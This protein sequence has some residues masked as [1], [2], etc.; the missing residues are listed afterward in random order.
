M[1][2]WVYLKTAE[3]LAVFWL[4]FA[5]L[6]A[7][8][9]RWRQKVLA[10]FV[11]VVYVLI[12][13]AFAGLLMFLDIKVRSEGINDWGFLPLLIV[14][15]LMNAVGF[16]GIARVGW[17]RH[18]EVA[19]PAA[20]DWPRLRLLLAVVVAVV[21]NLVTHWNLKLAARQRL[22]REEVEASVM[23]LSVMPGRPLDSEN[24]ALLYEP[25]LKRLAATDEELVP[26]DWADYSIRLDAQDPRLPEFLARHERDLRMLVRAVQRPHCYFG[27]TSIRDD[28]EW[29]IGRL[30]WVPQFREA[31]G[32][33]AA[34]ARVKLA[35]GD[36]DGASVNTAAVFRMARHATQDRT[37]IPVLA[38]LAID[39]LGIEC[40]QELLNHQ[41]LSADSL[42]GLKLDA[43][44]DYRR[45]L[46]RAWV[47][48][49][50][51]QIASLSRSL[52]D[53]AS[54]ITSEESDVFGDLVWPE[55]YPYF[56]DRELEA[57]RSTFREQR[58]AF[59]LPCPE[60]S[61][62]HAKFADEARRRSVL[63]AIV[64]T[65]LP[66]AVEPVMIGDARHRLA[67]LA[68]A[69]RQYKLE[70]GELPDSFD[71]LVPSFID[72]VPLDPFTD[73]PFKM[74]NVEGG[75][76]LYSAGVTSL[77]REDPKTKKKVK[78]EMLLKIE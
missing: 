65:A 55:F 23:A 20:R 32:L 44:V 46:K 19:S 34:D 59:D 24:A 16:I 67:R 45:T 35:E 17:R 22:A 13:F 72:E 70:H 18:G 50:A 61:E 1:T 8:V 54:A 4:V 69:L 39:R 43:S 36:V 51:I 14:S 71:K 68:I 42:N 15:V 52:R 11:S 64:L 47:M 60:L 28:K 49:E 31:A 29:K 30:D 75:M 12:V 57:M 7:C 74:E 9:V 62:R 38:S 6:T 21:L 66:G 73:E 3:D 48:E 10:I 77:D 53:G 41:D 78:A 26:K 2:N 76:R 25:V 63:T 27:P 37:I 58:A 33:V 5:L 40:L 56:I